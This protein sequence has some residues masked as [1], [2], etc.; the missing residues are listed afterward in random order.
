[1]Q[2]VLT[3]KLPHAA[4]LQQPVCSAVD[5]GRLGPTLDATAGASRAVAASW[6]LLWPGPCSTA[7][8]A[9]ACSTVSGDTGRPPCCALMPS[10]LC[11]EPCMPVAGMLTMCP[12]GR[13][14]D[15]SAEETHLDAIPAVWGAVHARG[16]YVDDVP[17]R[18]TESPS[19][20][21]DTP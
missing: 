8:A 11:G 15:H 7:A 14:N 2:I 17:C 12:A 3:F 19:G 13:R 10:P 4:A 1:M 20:W 5:V 18:E 16:T 21:S 6:A 9:A